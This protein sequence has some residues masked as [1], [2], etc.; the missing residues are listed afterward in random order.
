MPP[1][2][3]IDQPDMPAALRLFRFVAA[4]WIGHALTALVEVGVI[5]ELGRGSTT[6]TKLA[7]R[8]GC[9]LDA[10][11]MFLRAGSAARVLTEPEPGRF[12]LTDTGE[13]LRA[14]APESLQAI[15]QLSSVR[16]FTQAMT[17]ATQTLRTGKPVFASLFGLPMYDYLAE[18]AELADRFH[19][20]MNS[21]PAVGNLMSD[22]DLRAARHV[23][24]VGAGEGKLL[25]T[26]LTTHSHLRGTLF[27]RPEIV[28]NAEEQ[29]LGPAG[30]AERCDVIGGDFF[31]SIPAGGDIYLLSRILHNWDDASAVRILSNL[32]AAMKP[33]SH[34]LIIEMVPHPDDRSPVIAAISVWMLIQLGGRERS[35]NQYER[36]FEKADLRLNTFSHHPDAPSVLEV[37]IR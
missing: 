8:T 16:E 37:V 22:S 11:T 4:S 18:H 36:L 3:P 14:D 32:R 1:D 25:A 31:A 26:V 30:V 27:D 12:E 28:A 9:D 17:H 5:D 20:A 23:V 10:L 33:Q 29:I 24:D 19:R 13:L 2:C 21:T 7:T 34:A 35:L 6:I 15:F